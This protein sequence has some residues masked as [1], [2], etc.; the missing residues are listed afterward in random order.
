MTLTMALVTFTLE[1]WVSRSARGPVISLGELL[2][3]GFSCQ[4]I[5]LPNVPAPAEPQMSATHIEWHNNHL[6][7]YWDAHGVFFEGQ[8]PPSMGSEP[9]T[10]RPDAAWDVR[11]VLDSGSNSIPGFVALA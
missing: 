3:K 2:R 10:I 1:F 6:W 7:V 9:P 5:G 11:V 8:M 4:M